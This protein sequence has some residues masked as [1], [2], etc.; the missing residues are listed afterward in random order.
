MKE[1]LTKINAK[2]DNK[3]NKEWVDTIM[4]LKE[5]ILKNHDSAFYYND[6]WFL[7]NN[8]VICIMAPVYLQENEN[9]E[10][11]EDLEQNDVNNDSKNS[12]N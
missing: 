12:D 1:I 10:T 2:L 7:P 8:S 6:L 9:S 3:E 4:E 5:K 11:S